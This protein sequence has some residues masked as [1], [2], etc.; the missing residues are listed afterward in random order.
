[1]ASRENGPCLVL[2]ATKDPKGCRQ[3]IAEAVP[4]V[5][6]FLLKRCWDLWAVH[7]PSSD[8]RVG[9]TGPYASNALEAAIILRAD[10]E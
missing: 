8:V 10:N 1:M 6:Y 9:G 3:T 5:P 4:S 7:E 2:L